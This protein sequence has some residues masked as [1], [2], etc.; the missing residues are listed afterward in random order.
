M[1]NRRSLG[2]PP[3]SWSP[4]RLPLQK[5]WCA[6]QEL[7]YGDFDSVIVM[8]Q[9]PHTEAEVLAERVWTR[10]KLAGVK[11]PVDAVLSEADAGYGTPDLTINY[12]AS[13]EGTHP[14]PVLTPVNSY[15]SQ[16]GSYPGA[17]S[18]LTIE[19]E[20]AKS[21]TLANKTEGIFAPPGV[22]GSVTT[23]S[24]LYKLM[25]ELRKTPASLKAKQAFFA[26]PPSTCK[27]EKPLSPS[28]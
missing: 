28:L 25:A 23:V 1:P 15:S 20:P 22:K 5:R 18:R 11:R 14:P 17:V 27:A 2:S 6:E 3:R 8:A 16:D 24:L 19:A 12:P 13:S 10:L 21:Y 26:T 4:M 7:K 9:M